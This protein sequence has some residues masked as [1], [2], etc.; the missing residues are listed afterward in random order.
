MTRE[1]N[2][3]VIGIPGCSAVITALS[4]G[5]LDTSSFSFYGFVPTENKAKKQLFNE[6][7]TSKVKTKV[8]YESPKRIIKTLSELSNDIPECVVSVCSELTKIHEKCIYGKID[9]LITLKKSNHYD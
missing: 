2:I 6:I 7:K 9:D 8:I 5:G 1:N 4:I 3:K